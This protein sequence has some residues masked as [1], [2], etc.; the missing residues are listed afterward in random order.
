MRQIR[1]LLTQEPLP[2]STPR[3]FTERAGIERGFRNRQ[4]S[5]S[6]WDTAHVRVLRA[7]YDNMRLCCAG[8]F[9][10]SRRA[11]RRGIRKWNRVRLRGTK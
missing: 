9:I 11:I 2:C 5:D 7:A 6:V 4:A 8:M 1:L 3:K 10:R